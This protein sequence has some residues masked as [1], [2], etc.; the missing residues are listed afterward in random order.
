MPSEVT[1]NAP[2][3]AAYSPIAS[4]SSCCSQSCSCLDLYSLWG[5][6]S[7]HWQE[8]QMLAG[9]ALCVVGAVFS[10]FAGMTFYCLAF[11]TLGL[12]C[13]NG[14]RL[15]SQLPTFEEL[16]ETVSSLKQRNQELI[17]QIDK[18]AEQLIVFGKENGKFSSNNDRLGQ[19]IGEFS[20]E[21]SRLGQN[22]GE[23]SEENSR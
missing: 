20:E 12:L 13:L 21:N 7:E 6:V 8:Y 1:N 22:V 14:A 3:D 4:T 9:V 23:F 18:I 10:F 2:R 19:N 15:I 16:K 5:R 11:I 17:E